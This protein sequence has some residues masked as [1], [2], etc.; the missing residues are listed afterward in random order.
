MKNAYWLA[1]AGLVAFLFCT[2]P[3]KATDWTGTWGAAPLPPAVAGAGPPQLNSFSDQ[4]I[5]QVVRI[6]AGGD[7]VR[8]RF[9]NEYGTKPL[10]I[11]AAHISIVDADGNG[12]PASGKPVLLRVDPSSGYV[13]TT[14]PL[15]EEAI[16]DVFSFVLWQVGDPAFQNGPAAAAIAPSSLAP[17][18][19]TAPATPA[20]PTPPPAPSEPSLFRSPPR[21]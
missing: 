9:T 1:P 21:Q 6:S 2:V 8:I 11:G 7:R 10:A 18:A 5:R 14:R 15:R 20:T 4:T 17:A 13:P 16:A 19:A 12:D 3:A